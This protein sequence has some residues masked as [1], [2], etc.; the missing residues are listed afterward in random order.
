MKTPPHN[1]TTKLKSNSRRQP[2]SLPTRLG[3]RTDNVFP[4]VCLFARNL[5]GFG[6]TG[7]LHSLYVVDP[8][9]RTGMVEPD[10]PEPI[11]DIEEM[12]CILRVVT[13]AGKVVFEIVLDEPAAMA[14]AAKLV[15]AGQ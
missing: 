14:L 9:R 15:R 13:T 12:H 10:K 8:L 11:V 4:R 3:G 6:A 1:T 2:A 7:E 5:Q